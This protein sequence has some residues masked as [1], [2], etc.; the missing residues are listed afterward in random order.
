MLYKNLRDESPDVRLKAVKWIVFNWGVIPRGTKDYPI[1]VQQL[2]NYQHDVVK[3]FILQHVNKR[4]SSWSKVLAF[5]DSKKYAIFDSRV[6]IS[7]N[8]ILD[9]VDYGQRFYM[10][11]PRSDDLK[12]LFKNVRQSVRQKYHGKQKSYM[13]YF[14]YM[15]L[16][17]E[18]V[19]HKSGSNVLEVEMR[20]FAN[21]S[22]LALQYAKKHKI[23]Y[24][25]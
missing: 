21:S 10:P 19:K 15:N 13:G 11:E 7:L 6:A 17:N 8:T 4:I 2:G 22:R 24:N 25:P 20:L 5:A 9:D 16:L 12:V 1:W 23:P 14:D 3:N 18:M